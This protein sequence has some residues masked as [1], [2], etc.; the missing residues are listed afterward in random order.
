ML[1]MAHTNE[2]GQAM[3]FTSFLS[4]CAVI[5][6]AASAQAQ[7][8]CAPTSTLPTQNYPGARAIPSGNNLLMPAGKAE[9][10]KGQKV[11]IRGRVLD[12]QCIPVANATVELWQNSP[13][14]RWLLAGKDDLAA[15]GPVFAGAGRTYTDNEGNFSFVTAFPAPMNGR[16]PRVYVK[17]SGAGIPD[18]GTALYFSEDER[19]N[20]DPDYARLSAKAR[21]DTLIR[22]SSYGSEL[23]GDVELV[24]ATKTPYKTY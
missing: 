12:K 13:T 10:A 22:M 5:V 3:Q 21:A 6:V 8:D 1:G 15:A 14:G 24:I 16:A 19:N 7:S 17:V 18:I 11:T 9:E 2:R 4:A 23:Y 20:K